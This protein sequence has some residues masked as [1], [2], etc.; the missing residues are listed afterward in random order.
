MATAESLIHQIA[1]AGLDL[2]SLV[3]LRVAIGERIVGAKE[4]LEHQLR[5]LDGAASFG[6]AA[7]R[8]A[9]KRGNNAGRRSV[10][11]AGRNEGLTVGEA[12][13][14]AIAAGGGRLSTSQI[15]E[16]FDE[17]GDRRPINHAVLVLSGQLKVV[18]KERR[19]PGKRGRGGTVYRAAHIDRGTP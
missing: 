5:L 14:R 15:R 9:S 8:L 2:P 7:S 6:P 13:R 11:N 16:A 1:E 4:D 3:A 19:Q 12:V 17:V 18:G 10:H